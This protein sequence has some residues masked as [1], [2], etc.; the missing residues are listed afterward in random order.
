MINVPQKLQGFINESA[1]VWCPPGTAPAESRAEVSP[2]TETPLR[3]RPI[4]L[5]QARLI[6]R[7]NRVQNQSACQKKTNSSP[8]FLL[9][10]PSEHKDDTV[11]AVFEAVSWEIILLPP[12]PPPLP[13]YSPARPSG[14]GATSGLAAWVLAFVVGWRSCEGFRILG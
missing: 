4:S 7:F 3:T 10:L 6:Q 12:L 8:L 2:N 14:G 11:P 5:V 13:S 1:N 9:R